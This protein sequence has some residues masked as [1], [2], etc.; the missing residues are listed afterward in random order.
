MEHYRDLGPR[1]LYAPLAFSDIVHRPVLPAERS[2]YEKYASDVCF[3][4]GW[5]PRREAL[6]DAVAGLPDI[7][8]KIWGYGWNHLAD[9]RVTARRYFAMRRNSAGEPFKVRRNPR[10]A[11]A[12]QGAEI[13]D[14]QY[15]WA[16]SAARISLGFLRKICP[17][18]HTT[19]S[20]EIPA[21]GSM[22]IADRTTEHLAM[23]EE[24]KEAEFFDDATELLDKL[25]YYLAH[26]D[27]RKR[28]AQ[29]GFERCFRDGYSYRSRVVEI[30]DTV[31]R[32][33]SS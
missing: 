23:F 10:L 15:S 8:L 14:E 12:V 17:D 22:M 25:R 29:A 27:E 11:P 6:L 21:C 31:V 33:R 32:D 18:Q 24:G 7:K 28:V 16:I 20:F 4:G 9:G 2:T 1:I 3:V 19:R 26:E 30:M 13:Y 5:E